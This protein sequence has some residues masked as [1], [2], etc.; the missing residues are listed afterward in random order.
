VRLFRVQVAASHYSYA[1]GKFKHFISYIRYDVSCFVEQIH[2]IKE[3]ICVIGTG[4]LWTVAYTFE[5]YVEL[6]S[7]ESIL[8]LFIV[9][10]PSENI[11]GA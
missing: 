8:L 4:L 3:W 9:L 2:F 1:N 6:C 7:Q 10:V 11:S 5:R